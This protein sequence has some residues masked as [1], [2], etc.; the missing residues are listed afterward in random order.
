MEVDPRWSMMQLCRVTKGIFGVVGHA[1]RAYLGR[2][3]EQAE[4]HL[5]SLAHPSA[6]GLLTA[7]MSGAQGSGHGLRLL[8]CH[9]LYTF[10]RL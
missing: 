3:T 10:M 1:R 9:N 2:E 4:R 8:L 5:T 7:D 6:G